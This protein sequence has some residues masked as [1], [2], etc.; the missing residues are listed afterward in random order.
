[1]YRITIP[2]AATVGKESMTATVEAL[3]KS[4]QRY[5]YKTE[6]QHKSGALVCQI[7]VTAAEEE[8]FS[9]KDRLTP[10][11]VMN[12]SRFVERASVQNA[13]NDMFG[14]MVS[15]GWKVTLKEATILANEKIE[16]ERSDGTTEAYSPTNAEMVRLRHDLDHAETHWII[17]DKMALFQDAGWIVQE[18]RDGGYYILFKPNGNF[19]TVTFGRVDQA[20][21]AVKSAEEAVVAINAAARAAKIAEELNL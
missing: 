7:S 9:I 21:A 3:L 10:D 14:R 5:G 11:V 13:L 20:K 1:M 18:G 15:I 17:G 6:F 19:E 2:A 12:L 16:V 4:L 8:V